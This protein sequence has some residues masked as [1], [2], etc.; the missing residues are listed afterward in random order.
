[1]SSAGFVDIPL[2][3]FSG[4][5]S[6]I[7][8]T[9]LP[10]GA[11]PANQ[12]VAYELGDVKTRPGTGTGA[13]P[14]GANYPFAG[15]PTVNYIKQFIDQSAIKR[16]LMLD[17]LGN[18]WQENPQNTITSISSALVPSAWGK[19]TT[20][21]SREYI[22]FSDGKYGVDIPRQFDG[23]NFDRV[24]QVGPG[25][26]PS[27]TDEN[28]SYTAVAGPGG[29]FPNANLAI[30]ASP[31]GIIEVGNIATVA[32][33][34]GS[35][36]LM[37]IGDLITITGTTGGNYVGGWTVT[38]ILDATHF[39]II[40]PTTGIPADGGG[41]LANGGSIF[42]VVTTVNNQVAV[43]NLVVLAGMA[44]GGYNATFMV[45]AVV[46]ATTF[47]VFIANFGA[48][49]GGTDGG[50][51]IT[52]AGTIV[53]G[54]HG[55]TV[56]FITRQGYLTAP[57]PPINWTAA[58]AKRA[59]VANIPLGPPNVV[60]RLL[61]FTAAGG[62]KY[63]YTTGTFGSPQFLIADNT[64]TTLT[65]DFSDTQLLAGTDGTNLFDLI[66]L[67]E[68]LGNIDYAGRVFHW[69]ER[70]KIFNFINLTFDGGTASPTAPFPAGWTKGPLTTTGGNVDTA[71]SAWGG[72]Y[73]IDT[74]A[75]AGVMGCISQS[76]YQDPYGQVILSP[77]TQYGVRIRVRTGSQTND[78][79][80]VDLWSLSQGLIAS[81]SGIVNGVSTTGFTEII[82]NFNA[83]TPVVIPA[84]MV[85]RVYVTRNSGGGNFSIWLDSLEIFPQLV[86]NISSS[87]RASYFEDPESF[88]DVT[89]FLSIA[90]DNGQAIRAAFK[91]REKLY[92][93]KEGSLH[94]TED[95]GQNEPASWSIAEVSNKVGTFS[96]HGVDVGEEWAVIA[97]R[98]GLYIFWG[99]EPSKISQEIQPTWN[100]INW[101]QA[102][103]MWVKVDVLNKRIL[104]GAP[105]GESV[106][107]NTIF[108]FDYRGLDT[109]QEIADH[110]TV[111][112]SSY[113]GKILTIGNSAK[114]SVWNISGSSAAFVDR[115]DG[116]AHLF[117]GNATGNGKVYDLLDINLSDD[118]VGIPWS[119]S[120]YYSPSHTEEETYRLGSHR[121]LFGY[122]SG[123]VEG[124]GQMTITAQPSGN[125]TA[126][127]L[128]TINLTTASATAA[129]TAISRANGVVT[130][131]CAGGHNLTA[132]DSQVVMVGASDATFN[133]TWPL[134][135]ILNP[136]SFQFFANL[137]DLLG[138]AGGTAARL[139]RDF[140]MTINVPGERVS[141]TMA[142]AGNTA[143]TWFKLQKFVPSIKA[144]PWSPT[145]GAF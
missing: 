1:M 110:W 98:A 125:I 10:S 71:I 44:T 34:A 93:V 6:D 50:G 72:S 138:V 96:V 107:V 113:S 64:T 28:L 32:L 23:V 143:G 66:E 8:P 126:T 100:T 109:A 2:E 141:F 89:G 12:D 14:N 29:V 46:N 17:S 60:A 119:Y 58:G 105:T 102:H 39:Q 91:L 73:R 54:T 30:V 18:L 94:V 21:F 36:A 24:S 83:L 92:F 82:T 20:I 114:W 120:T 65:I 74:T 88:S 76:A 124:A 129:I 35:T 87:V 90:E 68:C 59:T 123:F 61:L 137:P 41:I 33:A 3:I 81:A 31:N 67:G 53:A 117:L 77:A 133:G 115:I 4:L 38:S 70:N 116:T 16:T 78:T 49:W 144:H 142:N 13:F 69:G 62:A 86:P 145:G 57:A 56:V 140:I 99:A 52:L 139:L 5:V 111:K 101:S 104:V 7:A 134:L 40:L 132:Y 106:R 112:Y 63:F 131:T 95:D 136:T 135:Q 9:D 37:K 51:T 130:V 45:R 55:I 84:D 22:D 79:W 27:V 97:G 75:A 128:A 118:G 48:G 108:Y 80:N 15:N 122:L 43:G 19:S 26:A 47:Q 25:I 85:L 11:S 103:H 121:K 127:Q 42:N